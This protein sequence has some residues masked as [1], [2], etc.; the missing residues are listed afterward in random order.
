MN[1]KT[2]ATEAK[3][4]VLSVYRNAQYTTDFTLGGL[5]GRHNGVT[6]V[7]FQTE[8]DED[9]DRAFYPLL[10]QMHVTRLPKG[11]EVFAPTEQAPAV[12][13]RYSA[14]LDTTAPRQMHLAPV[15]AGPQR[16]MASG[17]YAG[18]TDSRLSELMELLTGYRQNII[19]VHDRFEG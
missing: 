5:T 6:L 12:I 15:E 2:V 7:G 17:N 18:T 4:L 10:Q 1:T 8:A 9:E 3:G 19:S 16:G 13:L 11:C 14:T